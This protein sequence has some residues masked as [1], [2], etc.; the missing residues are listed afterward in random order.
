MTDRA[1]IA[2]RGSSNTILLVLLVFLALL[3]L[4]T[5]AA[6]TYGDAHIY[7]DGRTIEELE[8]WEV[9]GGVAIGILGAIFGLAMGVVG[10]VIGLAAAIVSIVLALAGVAAGLFITAGT[11]LGPFL[12][13]AAIILLLRRPK[14]SD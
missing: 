10:L 5:Y 8:P 14:A 4:G 3:A 11:L 6:Y 1:L 12:L 9:I 13:I 2:Q 7:I